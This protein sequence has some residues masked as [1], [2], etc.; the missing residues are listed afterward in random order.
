M[1]VRRFDISQRVRSFVPYQTR[2]KSKVI[3]ES[4]WSQIEITQV[5][6]PARTVSESIVQFLG[7]GDSFKKKRKKGKKPKKPKKKKA[8]GFLKKLLDFFS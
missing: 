1:G 6:S 3:E 8:K 4:V 2:R 5:V 7:L